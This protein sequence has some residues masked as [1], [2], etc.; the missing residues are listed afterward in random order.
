MNTKQNLHIHTTYVDG[1]DTPEEIVAEAIKRGFASIGFSEH[2][3]LK[4]SSFSN[5]LTA[6]RMAKYE[7]E[8]RDLKRKYQDKIDVFCG[9]EYD[10]HSDVDTKGLDYL[11]GSVHCLDINGKTLPFDRGYAETLDYINNNLDGNGLAFAEKYYETVARLP[12]RGK[13][14][15]IG[16]F[17]LVTKN[18]E[19]GGFIDTSSKSYLDMG[20]E[21]IHALKGKIP[22]F[23]VNTGAIARGYRSAPYPQMDFLKE[24]LRLGFG[25]VITSDCHDKSFIDCFYNEARE[26]LAEAGF[27]SKWIL[28]NT[29][30]SEVKL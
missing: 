22:L 18:N 19:K 30:F 21:A 28:T 4:Y 29:G 15:I 1:K 3:H 20:F 23:E 25:A 26:M 17:D 11:I 24:F 9:L 7:K 8:V 10:F 14:D 2:S 12:E 5:Q 13:F 6:E 16:H 27:R